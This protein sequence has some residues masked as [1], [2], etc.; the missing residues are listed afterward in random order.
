MVLSTMASLE[1]I[2]KHGYD[3]QPETAGTTMRDQERS[4]ARLVRYL[5][6]DPAQRPRE[7]YERQVRTERDEIGLVP[8]EESE[9]LE[10]PRA[11]AAPR[12][13]G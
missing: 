6:V 11:V 2:D 1:E 10:S 9:E 3:D 4:H 7:L 5:A 8:D 12:G 13:R